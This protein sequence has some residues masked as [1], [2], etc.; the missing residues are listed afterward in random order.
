MRLKMTEYDRF[1]SLM[2]ELTKVHALFPVALGVIFFPARIL[3]LTV[4]D[5]VLRL[6]MTLRPEKLLS[7]DLCPGKKEF[8]VAQIFARSQRNR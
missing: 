6:E 2:T 7:S 1:K 4:Q 5:R 8:A 3:V